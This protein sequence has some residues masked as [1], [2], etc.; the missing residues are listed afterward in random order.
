MPAENEWQERGACRGID[1]VLFFPVVEHEAYEAKAVCSMCPVKGACLEFA[2][3]HGE[4]F[5]IWGGY[6]TLERK[7]LMAERRA[8]ELLVAE[9]PQ[10]DPV[11][12]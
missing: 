11:L 3:E 6:T 1:V 12:G 10:R 2:L 5:G 9:T 4:R 8:V 7:E